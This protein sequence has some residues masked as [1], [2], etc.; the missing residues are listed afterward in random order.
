MVAPHLQ[1]PNVGNY[2]I[3][4]GYMTVQMQ[5]E[6]MY[7]DAGNTT[8]FEFDVKPTILPHFSTRQGV[9]TK[10]F[11]AVVQLEGTLRVTFDE[12][13]ARNLAMFMLGTVRESP[14]APDVV[15]DMFQ[16]PQLFAAM[17]F[18][19]TNTIGPQWKF[20]FPLVQLTP[21]KALSLISAGTGEWG[22]VDLQADILRDPVT[23]QFCIA[24]C[25]NF[26]ASGAP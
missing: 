8:L 22:T 5:G 11:T 9:R 15:I 1:S 13:T 10:D 19:P 4:R 20:V 17:I 23:Q 16:T 26:L 7:Q 6:T 24:T 21:Q 2:Y 3:G 12:L 18:Q 14:V 25:L